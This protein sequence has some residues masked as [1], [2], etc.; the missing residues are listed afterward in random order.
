MFEI[1]EAIL[2][3]SGDTHITPIFTILKGFGFMFETRKVDNSTI[4]HQLEIEKIQKNW[5]FQSDILVKQI[6]KIQIQGELELKKI[7]KNIILS[8]LTQK[9]IEYLREISTNDYFPYEV[10]VNAANAQIALS[11]YDLN[12]SSSSLD[13]LESAM[14][15]TFDCSEIYFPALNK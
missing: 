7:D 4:I 12:L 3:L 1:I 8:Y 13:S 14:H 15:V 9:K 11:T 10:R 6:A 5:D 2:T